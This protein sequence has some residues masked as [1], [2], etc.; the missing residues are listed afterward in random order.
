MFKSAKDAMT[1]RAAQSYIN[2]LISRYGV[3]REL[4]LDSERKSISVSCELVGETSPIAIE[5]STYELRQRD[6]K[7]YFSVVACRSSRPWLENVLN[8]H[9][10]GREF[11][12]PPWAAM[13]L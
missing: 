3:V 12:V 9:V 2:D 4:R 13:A 7:T 1:A 11:P 5:I 8:D 6:G 10:R